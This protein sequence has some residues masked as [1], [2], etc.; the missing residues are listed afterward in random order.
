MKRNSE[1]WDVLPGGQKA[2]EDLVNVLEYLMGRLKKMTQTL[3]CV[4]H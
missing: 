2:E 3:L 4:A 1:I